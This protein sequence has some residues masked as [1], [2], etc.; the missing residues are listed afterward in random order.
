MVIN[1]LDVDRHRIPLPQRFIVL[2]QWVNKMMNT[3][4]NVNNNKMNCK[5]SHKK[6]SQARR[7][8]SKTNKNSKKFSP[9]VDMFLIYIL[10]TFYWYLFI[11]LKLDFTIC[12]NQRRLLINAQYRCQTILCIGC[13]EKSANACLGWLD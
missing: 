12:Q 3:T 5:L 13:R 9:F 8:V 11:H 1:R 6:Y 7:K 2:T 10:H 4:V